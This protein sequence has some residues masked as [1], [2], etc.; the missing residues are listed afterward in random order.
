MRHRLEPS[1][2]ATTRRSPWSVR[3]LAPLLAA[4]AAAAGPP[5]A[6]DQ[7]AAADGRWLVATVA[8][9]T[10]AGGS[11]WRSDVAVVNRGGAGAEVAVTFL[12]PDGP[13]ERTAT[14]PAGGTREWRDVLVS[15][16]GYADDASVAG[17]LHLTS[18]SPL[19][20]TSRTY[21]QSAGGTY[22][23][24]LPA[25]VAADAAGPGDLALL[26]QLR[27]TADFYTNLGL[28]NLGDGE[29]A[30]RVTLVDAA[31]HPVGTTFQL[32][33]PAGSWKQAN[34]VFPAHDAGG[35][36]TAYAMLE[37]IQG[38]AVWGYAS[39]VD[40]T[41]RDPTTIPMTVVVPSKVGALG[42]GGPVVGRLQTSRPFP[43]SRPA[44][45]PPAA[46]PT[47]GVAGAASGRSSTDQ[48]TVTRRVDLGPYVAQSPPGPAVRVERESG[49]WI[50]LRP[51][52]RSSLDV[53]V[54]EPSE[55]AGDRDP[56]LGR[57]LGRPFGLAAADL[58]GDGIPDVVTGFADGDR[59][60]LA[61]SFGERDRHRTSF[62]PGSGASRR[63]SRLV[64]GLEASDRLALADVDG[65][66][67]PDAI[68]ARTGGDH[69]AVLRGTAD[70]SFERFGRRSVAGTID[71]FLVG[72]QGRRDGI[73][74]LALA[75]TDD[76]G[77]ALL[78]VAGRDGLLDGTAERVPLP[79]A[80]TDI[81]ADD[82]DGDGAL[83][84][85]VAAGE[86]LVVVRGSL[87]GRPAG[88][89]QPVA[90]DRITEVEL[91]EPAR[92]LAV[93][94]LHRRP[95]REVA[96][97][98]DSGAV[99]VVATDGEVLDHLDT[100][101]GAGAGVLA[102]RVSALPFDDLVLVDPARDRLSVR[103]LEG[104][105]DRDEAGRVVRTVSPQP[106]LE[107]TLRDGAVAVVPLRLN[108]DALHDLVV[109][110]TRGEPLTVLETELAGAFTV[111]DGGD[112]P[113]DDPGD[114]VCRTAADTCT[115]R[116]A[117]TE[118]ELADGGSTI[119]FAV[120]KVMPTAFLS[121]FGTVTLNGGG[122][123]EID[124]SANSADG[125]G[126]RLGGA[127]SAVRGLSF[128]SFSSIGLQLTGDNAVVTGCR[129]G[130]TPTGDV[131][132][133]G[134]GISMTGSDGST[135][136]GGAGNGNV[137]TTSAVFAGLRI[138]SGSVAVEGNGFGVSP[139]G[140]TPVPANPG[141]GIEI[142]SGSHSISGNRFAGTVGISVTSG[143]DGTLVTQNMLGVSDALAPILNEPTGIGLDLRGGAVTVRQNVLGQLAIGVKILGADGCVVEDNAIGWVYGDSPE[144][145]VSTGV[146][147][148]GRSGAAES[149]TI[150]GNT[151]AAVGTAVSVSSSSGP[152]EG[153]AVEDNDIGFQFGGGPG[154]PS[155]SSLVTVSQTSSPISG[156]RIVGNTLAGTSGAGIELRGNHLVGVTVSANSITATGQ[157]GIDLGGFGVTPN[158]GAPDADTG[159]NGLLNFPELVSVNGSQVTG[160][161]ESVPRAP[162]TVEL[163]W[164]PSCSEP[165]R[166]AKELLGS[167]AVGT[168]ADGVGAF[169]FE[170]PASFSGGHLTATTTDAEGSTSELSACVVY[171]SVAARVD[172]I[173]PSVAPNTTSDPGF[174]SEPLAVT[175]TGEGFARDARV[176]LRG[177]GG[178]PTATVTSVEGCLTAGP[179]TTVHAELSGFDGLLEGDRDVVVVD[180]DGGEASGGG[181][182]FVS[183]LYIHPLRF[184]QGPVD[185]AGDCTLPRPC[186]AEHDTLVRVPV[187]CRGAGCRA[188]K[189]QALARL[190]V[191]L[192]GRPVAG[193]P[194]APRN[195]FRADGAVEILASLDGYDVRERNRAQDTFDFLLEP[196]QLAGGELVLR[197][198]IDPRAPDRLPDP[199][200]EPGDLLVRERAGLE[201]ARSQRDLDVVYLVE[202]GSPAA[203]ARAAGQFD[204]LGAA[205]PVSAGD[206]F[207]AP[208]P[209]AIP[210][211]EEFDTLRRLG[212]WFGEYRRAGGTATHAVLF[213]GS[214]ATA[215]DDGLSTCGL[216]GSILAGFSYG[217]GEPVVLV[218]LGDDGRTAVTV[219][220]EL[221][222]TFGLGET[223]DS[224]TVSDANPRTAECEPNGCLVEEG[225]VDLLLG[226]ASVRN[227][228]FP[229]L[230]ASLKRDFMGSANRGSTWT[231]RRTWDHLYDRLHLGVG[232]LAA[233]GDWLTVSG[234]V[235]STG[236]ALDP[237]VRFAG[238]AEATGLPPGEWTLRLEGAAGSVLAEHPFSVVAIPTGYD[239]A[240]ETRPF[241]L[242]VPEPAGVAR[243][244]VLENGAER[245]AVTVSSA[246]PTVT[247]T[248]PAAGASLTGPTTVAWT[249]SDADGDELL[250]TVLASADGAAFTPVAVDVAGT[251]VSLDPAAW[252]ATSAGA[253]RVVVSD[254]WHVGQAEV[255]GIQVAASPP[256]VAFVSPAD[257]AV[258]GGGEPLLIRV[259]AW[260]AEDGALPGTA[261]SVRSDVDGPLGDGPT[262]DVVLSPGVHRLT[263]TATDH[264]GASG[265]AQLTVTVAG[266]EGDLAV[267]AQASPQLG[268]AP[269]DVDF[270]AAAAGGVPPYAAQWLFGDS[271]VG[272]G[273]R[274]S[275]RYTAEGT[276]P[277]TV[278]VTDGR[279]R[280]VDDRSLTIVVGDQGPLDR[281]WFV[282]TVAHAT[283]FG[284]S[285]WRSDVAV[286]NPGAAPARLRLTLT[287]GSTTERT[288]VVPAGGALEWRDVV[289][290]L[291][292]FDDQ[293]SVS[294]S[295]LLAADR[296]LVV[297]SRTYNQSSGG[298]FGQ[299]L[300][301]VDAGGP[302]VAG[303]RGVLPQ[304]RSDAGFYTN[305]GF[306]NTGD[307]GVTVRVTYLGADGSAVGSA[308]E[309]SVAACRWKQLNDV[310]SG[311]GDVPVAYGVVEVTSGAGSVW[312]YAS[313][314]DRSTRDPTT[315]PMLR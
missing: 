289:V 166:P 229:G 234:S 118:A 258:V 62:D 86:R 124:G 213:T 140:S 299:Y 93:G 21:N 122:T 237:V 215:S 87:R 269:L 275:H 108:Q 61:T 79:A 297:S 120:S 5:D 80:A 209:A 22:G 89:P 186:V 208:A 265:Q 123:V 232:K 27:D 84:L 291:F 130:I 310:F 292:G 30:V 81:A 266:G 195:P 19:A 10:G 23:Q 2:A 293:A 47:K 125:N 48:S 203:L 254:G 304:L 6:G 167:V 211:G 64:G 261:I 90:A 147:V 244:A 12:A 16:F 281:L 181:L 235:S 239:S 128:H 35:Q 127:D 83:D 267:V 51:A 146:T 183:S 314:V 149:T 29:A 138:S 158:D 159:P 216:Y 7:P 223:Y 105:V 184:Q 54:D 126:P 173:A 308:V 100:G 73:A 248:Q 260:D 180:P 69:V 152:V 133:N 141:K 8:H 207:T 259:A 57:L 56:A 164:S 279:G 219:A 66:R 212:R 313:V 131:R 191:T 192:A 104:R 151:F 257:G 102:A 277:V 214:L 298:T 252:P 157:T 217:C 37:V 4:A 91:P 312:A 74:D 114:G 206:L 227:P 15:L 307:T 220:H 155:E 294:G 205:Y 165:A 49:P 218:R 284:D 230:T 113:D 247:I 190:S 264:D 170:V 242:T 40:R 295:L 26:P 236:V 59:S 116:A 163:F 187:T 240:P 288:V 99:W 24:F 273:L 222:H 143:G 251:S 65:D 301:P 263:A 172:D 11:R 44:P 60:A 107:L 1:A 45:R 179:C 287:R 276:Y 121:T 156:V 34:D 150:S 282:A 171:G 18:A 136:G 262:L 270:T 249:A 115:L 77:P 233:A 285:R 154:P 241:A 300:P 290:S 311:S 106:P 189:E 36:T 302:L 243:I 185:A 41:T 238:E 272:G 132:E 13:R 76:R 268:P 145:A 111:D 139:D 188:G 169:T 201:L 226:T 25:L 198:A 119:G 50:L 177:A 200:A 315:I 17:A 305:V 98:G 142:G 117:F 137:F 110:G 134:S 246:T 221:G 160:R 306:V 3:V 271:A 144:V 182:F 175:I 38:E 253:V 28:L 153:L 280:T 94:D 92:R 255:G 42:S 82:V 197:A 231:D 168:D 72:E 95:G 224:P 278:S 161:L 194:L 202:D 14:V 71:A 176:E 75:V 68:L 85:V 196:D 296:P 52:G 20:V 39:V 33:A 96:I 9:S 228:L 32:R 148:S 286:V 103:N 109:V 135:I 63:T 46:G 283:G 58:D 193:S 245:A 250:A 309:T 174:F 88:G 129:F 178:N 199:A 225:T 70:G 303:G 204:F 67:R 78:L 101:L 97:L 43:A 31:G 162:Y 256:A 55:A 53:V 112:A 274:A 210:F